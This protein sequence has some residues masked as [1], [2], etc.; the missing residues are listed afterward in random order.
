MANDETWRQNL[1][2]ISTDPALRLWTGYGEIWSYPVKPAPA[3]RH[4]GRCRGMIAP[5]GAGTSS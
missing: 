4:A 1:I 3:L 2:T 5:T